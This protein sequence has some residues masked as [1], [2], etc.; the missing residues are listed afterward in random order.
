MNR[1]YENSV[2]PRSKT[3]PYLVLVYSEWCVLCLHILPL[4]QRLVDDLIPIG[5]NLATVNY[6]KEIEL[7]QKLGGRRD[8]LPHV[9]FVIDSKIL[10]YKEDQ[11]S[12]VRV[13]GKLFIFILKHHTILLIWLGN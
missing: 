7:A 12:I 8:Q 9:A 11:F 4:W 13:I 1:G 10:H 5:I 6:E 3:Q 2:F